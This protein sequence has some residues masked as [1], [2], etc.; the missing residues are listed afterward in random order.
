MSVFTPETIVKLLNEKG[1]VMSLSEAFDV[2]QTIFDMH[3]DRLIIIE[4]NAYDGG[5]EVGKNSAERTMYHQGFNE[6]RIKGRE[7]E[8]SYLRRTINEARE[9]MRPLAIHIVHD[10]WNNDV[11][12]KV[13]KIKMIKRFRNETKMGLKFCK[14]LIDEEY[15]IYE[16]STRYD[17]KVCD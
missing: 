15:A 10:M 14:D 5:V 16:T 4:N 8:Q 2:A 9:T 6:G 3:C 7:E 11:D 1:V 17:C 13:H 12:Q